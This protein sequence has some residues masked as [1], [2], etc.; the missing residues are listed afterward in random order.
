MNLLKKYD[1][2]EVTIKHSKL[3]NK[4]A[5]LLAKNIV[6]VNKE[7]VNKASLYHDID[8]KQMTLG[9]HGI[10]GADIL[11]KEGFS[12]ELCE[13]VKL[14]PVD[15]VDKLKTIEQKIVF[16]ADKRVR[17]DYIVSVHERF[18]IWRSNVD[19]NFPFDIDTELKVKQLEDE[20]FE[21][22]SF[23]PEHLAEMIENE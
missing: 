9:Q 19:E 4:I 1:L 21:H 10:K 13:I 2:D 8:K 16:Y 12:P 14:H 15:N 22:L 7:L 18:E 6:G 3:V 11:K 23:R 5:N 20:L 17:H